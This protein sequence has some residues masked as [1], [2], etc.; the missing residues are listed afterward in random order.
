MKNKNFIII[1]CLFI[2]VFSANAISFKASAPKMVVAGEQFQ[3][4]YTIDAGNAQ[5]IRVP[6][7]PLFKILANFQS[8]SQSTQVINGKASSQTEVS[9]I[10]TLVAEKEGEYTIP[11]AT[12]TVAGKKYTSNSLTI[13]VKKG[14]LQSAATV[15][16]SNAITERN[17]FVRAIPS[18]IKLYEHDYLLLT[19]KLYSQ[20]EIVSLSNRKIPDFKDFIVKEIDE[21]DSKQFDIE[22]YNGE[23]YNTIILYQALIYPQKNGTIKIGKA[24]FEPIVRIYSPGQMQSIFADP[25]QNV[26]KTLVAPEVAITV[27]KLPAEGKPAHFNNLVGE[28]SIN[29]SLSASKAKQNEPLTLTYTISGKGDMKL[30]EFPKLVFDSNLEVYDP[31]IDVTYT[32][33]GDDISSKKTIEYLVI[34]RKEGVFAMPNWTLSYFD[35]KTNSYKTTNSQIVKLEVTGINTNTENLQQ[36]QFSTTDESIIKYFLLVIIFI[37]IL[38]VVLFFIFYKKKKQNKPE[39]NNQILFQLESLKDHLQKNDK[40]KFYDG[41]LKILWNLLSEKLS[42]PIA[43]L[44]KENVL[45]ALS[46]NGFTKEES[47]EILGIWSEC[48]FARYSPTSDTQAMDKIYDRIIN[49][50]RYL[51]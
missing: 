38:A 49:V 36:N 41:V 6:E 16:K 31:K 42:I 27:D 22:E 25:Y 19:Y 21:S 50:I 43:A 17:L 35:T 26:R 7:M 5:N 18:K 4:T 3:L 15:T 39:D 33:N 40:E 11:P 30:I 32:N 29:T 51:K 13:K 47:D 28:F 20:V 48:E 2:T 44:T 37:L 1:F 46:K 24:S 12:I 9:Y 34:P 23:Q 10:Y 14:V 45:I 8:R